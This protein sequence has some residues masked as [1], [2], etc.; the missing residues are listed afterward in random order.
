M[1]GERH[2]PITLLIPLRGDKC[3]GTLSMQHLSPFL[4]CEGK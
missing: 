2:L 4:V 1:Q 3:C